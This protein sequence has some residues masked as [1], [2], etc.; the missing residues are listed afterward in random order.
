MTNSLSG[1]EIHNIHHI[2]SFDSF[3]LEYWENYRYN[4]IKNVLLKIKNTE[5]KG[6]DPIEFLWNEYYIEKLSA[7]DIYDKYAHYWNYKNSTKDTF[8]KFFHKRLGWNLRKPSETTNRTKNKIIIKTYENIEKQRIE[9]KNE[10]LKAIKILERIS[11]NKEKY[12][13]DKNVLS[14]LKNNNERIKYVLNKK[15]YITEDN[16]NQTIHK[17]INKYW[18]AK[19]SLII[20]GIL[21]NEWFKDIKSNKCRISEIKNIRV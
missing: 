20:Q 12:D 6:E 1:K 7:A 21:D 16:F 11:K 13:V 15:W 19:T 9:S 5:A 14:E 2:K 18:I 3:L 8:E 10:V 4:K 17:L